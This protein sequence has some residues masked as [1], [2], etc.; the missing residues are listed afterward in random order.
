ML[1]LNCYH[2]LINE[3]EVKAARAA[4]SGLS[5]ELLLMY[6][7]HVAL[8]DLVQY[9]RPDVSSESMCEMVIKQTMKT[10]RSDACAIV[11]IGKSTL[12]SMIQGS[13]LIH[14]E[15]IQG[16]L[17]KCQGRSRQ[18]DVILHRGKSETGET[19]WSKMWNLVGVEVESNELGTVWLVLLSCQREYGTEDI[20]ILKAV[21]RII[22]SHQCMY[23]KQKEHELGLLRLFEELTTAIDNRDPFT[24][25][26]SLRVAALS[27]QI[28]KMM[29]LT[30][31]ECETV[32]RSAILHD[33]GKI[34]I[35]EGLLGK[36]EMLSAL[37]FKRIAQHPEVGFQLL[38]MVP[39]L[40]NVL[41]GV[42]Y[43]H[44]RYDGKGYPCRLAK[45]SIP[46]H[47]RIIAVADACDAMRS[48]RPYRPAMSEEQVLAN[49][50]SGKGSQWDPQVVAVVTANWREI[51]Q[52]WQASGEVYAAFHGTMIH[53][54]HQFSSK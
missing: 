39:F 34:V 42:R 17:L 54:C 18:P 36:P 29:G 27:F 16:L 31:Q 10:L 48:A 6:E 26:H 30:S 51:C 14:M 20:G 52:T 25:G 47:A 4:V 9:V 15:Q 24:E 50:E 35:E 28:A 44:E 43:H 41:D 33:L 45:E 49:L 8:V 46:L 5:D 22:A 13:D 7:A 40:E 19:S 53:D 38:R 3:Q 11:P 32:R 21:S 2:R 12:S 1:L 23:K 37:E